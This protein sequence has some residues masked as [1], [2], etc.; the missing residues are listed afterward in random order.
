MLVLTFRVADIPYA[1]AVKR[2]AEVVPRVGL[3]ALPHAPSHLVGLLHYRGGVVPVVDLGILMGGEI[4]RERLDTR[5]VLVDAGG[6]SGGLVGLVAERV[7]DV[8]KVDESRKAVVGIEVEGAPYLG[9]VFEVE[10]GLLQLIEPARILG[11]LSVTEARV[12]AS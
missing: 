4:C 3:R 1:V 7:D 2:V 10:D 12:D 6:E 8:R 9:T 11:G 5:I